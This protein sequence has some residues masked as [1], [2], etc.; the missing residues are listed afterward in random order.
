MLSP[1]SYSMPLGSL[2]VPG[3]SQ[4]TSKLL[5]LFPHD[6]RCRWHI[7]FSLSGPFVTLQGALMGLGGSIIS[8]EPF[9]LFEAPRLAGSERSAKKLELDTGTLR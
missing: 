9:F 6:K 2:L 5:H 8:A 1:S 3:A 4:P 7:Y